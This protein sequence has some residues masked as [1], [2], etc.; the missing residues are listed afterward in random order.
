MWEKE[1]IGRIHIQQ[2]NHPSRTR[3][4][5]SPDPVRINN[6]NFLER[7]GQTL[8]AL[9]ITFDKNLCF[10]VPSTAAPHLCVSLSLTTPVV[11]D[12]ASKNDS[13]PIDEN[14][15]LNLAKCYR[16]QRYLEH[17]F[18]HIHGPGGQSQIFDS[19]S[20]L[21]TFVRAPVGRLHENVSGNLRHNFVKA[22]LA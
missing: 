20:V 16:I 22:Y 19:T 18:T 14:I 17:G 8:Y 9:W 5:I 3:D 1:S 11:V 7:P 13:N 2:F 15:T 6:C 12:S 4:D 10:K 21:K